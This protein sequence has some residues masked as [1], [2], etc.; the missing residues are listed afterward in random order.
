MKFKPFDRLLSAKDIFI[1]CDQNQGTFRSVMHQ[2]YYAAFNQLSAE[3]DNRLFYP[4][5]PDVKKSSIHKAYLDACI[6][7]HDTLAE[8]HNDFEHLESVINDF[9]RL[10]GLRRVSDYE[11]NKIVNKGEAELSLQL[12]NRIFDAIEKIT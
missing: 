3:I 7:K 8:N 5:D 11:I 1:K 9:R 10:R 4:I 2:C 6:N 12:S